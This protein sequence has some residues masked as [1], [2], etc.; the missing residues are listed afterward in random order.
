MIFQFQSSYFSSYSQLKNIF[1]KFY[2]ITILKKNRLRFLHLLPVRFIIMKVKANYNSWW[3]SYLRDDYCEIYVTIFMILFLLL[4]RRLLLLYYIIMD[5]RLI[6][7]CI[8][9]L[10]EHEDKYLCQTVCNLLIIILYTTDI[11]CDFILF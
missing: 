9:L 5:G 10:F 8:L 7:W 6:F 3:F 1:K 2:S 11:L 4:L